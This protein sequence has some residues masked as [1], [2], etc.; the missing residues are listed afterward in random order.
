MG[1]HPHNKRPTK[2]TGVRTWRVQGANVE[3]RNDDVNGALRRL[4]K[5]LETDNRQKDLAKH[6]YYEKPSVKRKRER[7]AAVKRQQK[8]QQNSKPQ[9]SRNPRGS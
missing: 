7:A 5:I 6:E 4:R 1:K 3:V 8:Q 2:G 9:R